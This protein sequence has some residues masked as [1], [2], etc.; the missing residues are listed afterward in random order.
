M[1]SLLCLMGST[2]LAFWKDKLAQLTWKGGG[3]RAFGGTTLSE[4][5]ESLRPSHIPSVS[6]ISSSGPSGLPGSPLCTCGCVHLAQGRSHRQ[7]FL[8][9]HVGGL[10]K[11]CRQQQLQPESFFFFTQGPAAKRPEDI[12]WRKKM[13]SEHKQVNNFFF[14]FANEFAF[15]DF[16]IYIIIFLNPSYTQATCPIK[17]RILKTYL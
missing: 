16:E 1:W 2:S 10:W 4:K 7:P 15:T 5:C 13:T 14:F 11:L 12:K 17:G 3:W 9:E 8:P 6:C